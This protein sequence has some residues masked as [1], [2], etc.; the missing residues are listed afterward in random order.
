MAQRLHTTSKQERA[1]RGKSKPANGLLSALNPQ[2]LLAPHEMA[3]CIDEAGRGCLAGPVVASAVLFPANFAFDDLLPGLD[4]SKRLTAR[5]RV[6][7]AALVT[8]HCLA[9]GVGLSWQQEIDCVNILNATFRAMSRAV[10]SLAHRLER[11]S[12]GA[13]LP[14]LLIDG[15]KVIP[16]AHWEFCASGVPVSA[17]AWEQYFPLPLSVQPHRIPA[18]PAQRAIVGGD[19]LV[20][21]ISAAS[22]VAKTVR[23]GVMDSLDR[24]FPRYGFARHKGYGTREHLAAVQK[25]GPCALHRMTFRGVREESG[26]AEEQLRLV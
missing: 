25:F 23:D 12:P 21:G 14:M 2:T 26:A 18:L 6:L 22:I 9:Y 17:L 10:L 24:H 13:S 1:K 4:D 3:I 15:N 7:L 19:A 11:Q 16:K 5:Q 8:E 20:P